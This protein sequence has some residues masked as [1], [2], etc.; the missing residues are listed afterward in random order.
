MTTDELEKEYRERPDDELLLLASAPEQLTPEANAAL[1]CELG[2][3]KLV[4]EQ[5]AQSNLQQPRAA[6]VSARFVH[7]SLME[8]MRKSWT[9]FCSLS[10]LKRFGIVAVT[11]F[12]LGAPCWRAWQN[13]RDGELELLY[14]S[15]FTGNLESVRKMSADRLFGGT[16]WLERL[17]RDKYADA[18]ARVEAIKRLS[19][20]H[21]ASPRPLVPLL[22]IEVPYVVRHETARFFVVRGCDD[23]CIRM[24]L[25][26]LHAMWAGHLMLEAERS[27]DTR[28]WGADE[29]KLTAD[30]RASSEAD[31]LTLVNSN[32]CAALRIFGT[33]YSIDVSFGTKLRTALKPC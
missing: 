31:Y 33:D 20:N 29:K 6:S 7:L 23:D 8:E 25:D 13:A 26:S 14:N 3:R 22:W 11:L 9:R 10:P 2:R 4:R 12:L 32:P 21:S 24:A 28:E 27:P 1:A 30:L 15:A 19:E 18:Y 17:A 5:Y 16:E